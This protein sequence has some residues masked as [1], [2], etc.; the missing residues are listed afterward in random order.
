VIARYN[1]DPENRD[2]ALADSEKVLLVVTQPFSNHNA[3]DLAFGPDGYLYIG[4]GDGGNADDPGN[5]SQNPLDLLGKM[6]RIDVDN[7]DPYS[8]PEDNPYADTDFA[9]DEIWAMGLRN[10]WRFSFDRL[11]GDLYIAD[12]GQNQWEEINFQPATSTGGENYGWRCYEGDEAYITA[13]CQDRDQYTFPMFAYGHEG[14]NCSGSVTGGFRYYGSSGE[15]YGLYIFVDYCTGKF[16]GLNPADSTATVLLEGNGGVYTSFGE[17]SDGELY[18]ASA[19]GEIFRI[20][21][22][23]TASSTDIYSRNI[24]IYPVPASDHIY[25]DIPD[26]RPDALKEVSIYTAQG[27]KALYLSAIKENKIAVGSLPSGVYV[28]IANVGNRLY[29]GRFVITK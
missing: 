17:S 27:M 16:Y 2:E 7:G 14:F 28:L 25:L 4:F 5:R 18:L 29:Q 15:L 9:L 24:N 20:K 3:G 21:G 1:V 19:T 26:Q 6:L 23:G 12:V 8:I 22:P 10:P 13:G 11:N